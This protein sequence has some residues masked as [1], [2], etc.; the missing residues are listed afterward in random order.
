ML[1]EVLNIDCP[2]NHIEEIL[3][4]ALDIALDKKAPERKRERRRK[5]EAVKRKIP[6]GRA[7]D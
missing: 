2:H 5:R 1:A 4:K 7:A 3:D 6:P